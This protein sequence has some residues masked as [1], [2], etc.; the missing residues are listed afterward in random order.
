MRVSK[1]REMVKDR[2]AWHAAVHGIA[3]SWTRLSDWTELSTQESFPSLTPTEGVR[4]LGLS[5]D[6]GNSCLSTHLPAGF[7]S[8]RRAFFR[9]YPWCKNDTPGTGGA[10]TAEGR[11]PQGRRHG[12]SDLSI[13]DFCTASPGLP[14]LVCPKVSLLFGMSQPFPVPVHGL[15]ASSCYS[16]LLRSYPT[17]WPYPSPTPTL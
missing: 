2:E 8:V 10:Q 12:F 3:K 1:L 9:Q 4:F 17:S 7:W 11:G 14:L 6:L 5:E 13:L 15:A 16:L